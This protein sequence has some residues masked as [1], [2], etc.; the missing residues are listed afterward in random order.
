M[1]HVCAAMAMAVLVLGGAARTRAEMD[2]D[3]MVRFDDVETTCVC[4]ARWEECCE[5]ACLL[6]PCFSSCPGDGVHVLTP[7][8][9]LCTPVH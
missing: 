2:M 4:E 8:S 1:K 7:W 9:H 5:A 6:R 3:D